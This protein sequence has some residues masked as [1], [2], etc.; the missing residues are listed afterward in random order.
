M[1]QDLFPYDLT[2][3]EEED[4]RRWEKAQLEKKAKERKKNNFTV[5]AVNLFRGKNDKIKLREA[6]SFSD[7]VR[8]YKA[9][10]SEQQKK[11][12]VFKFRT[13]NPPPWDI[14]PNINWN[15]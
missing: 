10:I 3:A 1:M 2:T 11:G 14:R 4:K 15:K 12:R 13:H 9:W 5:K 7:H 6:N 8:L